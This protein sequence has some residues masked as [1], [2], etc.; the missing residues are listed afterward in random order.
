MRFSATVSS[1]DEFNWTEAALD[2]FRVVEAGVSAVSEEETEAN[3]MNI[4]PNPSTGQFVVEWSDN[5]LMKEQTT[6]DILDVN[7]RIL[8]SQYVAKGAARL[9]IHPDLNPGI[10]FC[11]LSSVKEKSQLAKL[12][13]L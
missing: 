8:H 2:R 1:S 4:Y 12:I 6:L 3:K 13:I 5:H 7:G 10:Y 9:S 11:R